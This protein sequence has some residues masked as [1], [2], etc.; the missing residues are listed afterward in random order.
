MAK[1]KAAAKAAPEVEVAQPEIKATNEMQEVVI[2]QKPKRVEK[3][4]KTLDDGWEI[5]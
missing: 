4:Y 2:E 5:T 1:K 3:K